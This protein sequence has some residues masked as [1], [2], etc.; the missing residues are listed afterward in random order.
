MSGNSYL[1]LGNVWQV[2][3]SPWTIPALMLVVMTGLCFL[4]IEAGGLITA[5]SAA[6]YSLRLNPLD[7]LVGGVQKLIDEVAGRISG[8]PGCY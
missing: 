3:L 7:M 8:L 2:L 4:M 5:Y 6:A 1:T